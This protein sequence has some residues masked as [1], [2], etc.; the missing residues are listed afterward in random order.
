MDLFL[1]YLAVSV[2]V[3]SSLIIYFREHLRKQ[4][5]WY[6]LGM[7]A[8]MVITNWNEYW[9]MMFFSLV[10]FFQVPPFSVEEKLLTKAA[11]SD[12]RFKRWQRKK[13]K[14]V[15]FIVYILCMILLSAFVT[16]ISGDG[17]IH[18]ILIG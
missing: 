15:Q 8:F 3:T 18:F 7:L 17:N 10:V 14:F 12:N 11:N 1:F 9:W 5:G 2:I 6:L 4:I 16:W 13:G